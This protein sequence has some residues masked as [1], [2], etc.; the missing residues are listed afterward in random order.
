MKKMISF[1]LI[2]LLSLNIYAKELNYNIVSLS[3]SAEKTVARDTMRVVFAIEEQGKNRQEVSN[4]TTTRSNRVLQAARQ[5]NVLKA[6]LSSRNTYSLSPNNKNTMQWQDR[7]TITVVSTDFNA[8]EKF[9]A[10]VQKYAAVQSLSFYPSHKTQRQLEDELVRQAIQS[11]QTKAQSIA[12]A[13]GKK[14]YEIVQLNINQQH[15]HHTPMMYRSNAVMASSV[16]AVTPDT[17]AGEERIQL[18]VS[19]SIQV[20]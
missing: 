4:K 15:N 11:F 8:L 7:A 10:Q 2:S 9:I 1:L 13:L 18:N 3:A 20:R 5:K 19:G 6:E 16:D 17:E 12:Q 14:Q